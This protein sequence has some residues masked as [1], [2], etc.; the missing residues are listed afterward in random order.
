MPA[1][2]VVVMGVSASGKSTVG[3][4]LARDL[5]VPFVDGDDLHPAANVAK[6][7]RG[8][9]LDDAD[10]MPWLDAIGARLAEAAGHGGLVVACSALKRAY[11]DRLRA[12]APT[13]VFV[14]VWADPET[15]VRRATAR[16][17]HFMPA[18]LLVSQLATLEPLAVDEPGAVFDVSAGDADRVAADAAR[19]VAQHAGSSL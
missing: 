14:H 13:T 10:R 6:M 5:G 2:A 18:S 17:G 12:A 3:A 19:W 16:T 7:S 8:V 1:P 11:R 9:P 15:L 4:A